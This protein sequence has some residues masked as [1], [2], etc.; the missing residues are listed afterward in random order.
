M[1]SD[2]DPMNK[3]CTLYN[4]EL[5][6][7]MGEGGSK[8]CVFPGKLGLQEVPGKCSNVIFTCC[9]SPFCEKKQGQRQTF[10]SSA[11][12]TSQEGTEEQYTHTVC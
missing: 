3:C 10:D 5:I 2:V 8:C 1:I 4:A 9:F 11:K 7:F 6:A 12:E